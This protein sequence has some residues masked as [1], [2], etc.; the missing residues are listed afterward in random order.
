MEDKIGTCD[1][2]DSENIKARYS[3]ARDEWLCEGCYDYTASIM[4]GEIMDD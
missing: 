1:I 2:C 3:P 4:F